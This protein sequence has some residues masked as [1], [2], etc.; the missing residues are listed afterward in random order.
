MDTEARER[1]CQQQEEVES[2]GEETWWRR[3]VEI[4]LYWTAVVLC[5]FRKAPACGSLGNHMSADLKTQQGLPLSVQHQRLSIPYMTLA[6][7]SEEPHNSL[8]ST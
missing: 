4:N 2:V 6:V 1:V 5:Q 3:E 8:C 7:S